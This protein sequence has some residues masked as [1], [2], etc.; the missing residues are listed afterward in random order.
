ML[1]PAEEAAT[2]ALPPGY[3]LEL[4]ASDPDVIC[5]VLCAWDGDGRMY[6]A[7]MRSYM[8][9]INGSNAHTPVSRVSRWESTKGDGVYDKHTVFADHL[10]LPRMVLPLDDRV[11]DPRDRHQGHRQPTAM[12]TAR[13]RGRTS[14]RRSTKA[15]KQEGNLEHQPSGLV[16]DIDNWIYVTNQSERF[17]FTHG[18]VGT[19]AKLPFHPGQWGIGTDDT[20]QVMFSTAGSENGRRTISR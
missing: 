14:G 6:V 5:P 4:V 7:E 16:W 1:S 8:L 9:N 12:L 13:R 18:K 3:H 19:V 2:I 11:L 20:G 15:A 10:M 17:R